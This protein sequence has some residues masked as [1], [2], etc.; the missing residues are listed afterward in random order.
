MNHPD[1]DVT[2]DECVERLRRGETVADWLAS[3]P[4]ADGEWAALVTMAAQLV[5]LPELSPT[6][7]ATAVGKEK[8]LAAATAVFAPPTPT[9]VHN[10]FIAWVQT[11]TRPLSKEKITMQRIW[12]ATALALFVFLIGSVLAVG[13][14][15]QSLPG[16]L[17]YPVKRSW[18]NTRLTLTFD[19]Q[20]RQAMQTQFQTQRLQEIE[21]LIS[22]GQSATVEF[23]GVLEAISEGKWLVSGLEVQVNADTAVTGSPAVGYRVRIRAHILNSGALLALAAHVDDVI[24]VISQPPTPTATH[25]HTATPHHTVTPVA[26][27]TPHPTRTPHP[28]KTAHPPTPTCR[29]AKCATPTHDPTATCAPA[30]C[31]THTPHPPTATATPPNAPTAT[32]VP[33][34]NCSSPTPPPTCEPANCAT[35]T[36]HPPTPTP[37]NA[38]TATCVPGTNCGTH[39]PVP[40]TCEPAHCATHT[41]HPPT[42]TATPPNAPTATCVPGTSCGTHTPTPAPSPTCDPMHCATHTPH[43]PTATATPPNAP[44]ATCVPGTNCGTHTPTPTPPPTCEPAHCATHTPHPPT[45]TATPP[46]GPTATCEPAHCGTHTPTPHP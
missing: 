13:A 28:T 16:E 31:A 23:T 25:A 24:S 9:P 44:T 12:Q 34:G 38:P 11:L 32:C 19:E 2:I 1:E 40:P 15:A 21:A 3:Y 37:P 30:H 17:L 36:P 20:A 5:A 43:P 41:P 14:S 18:E 4:A 42:A 33:G 45:A 39:T 46:H 27:H 22:S 7:A 29:P 8:M 26:T 6:P 35:H 10:P